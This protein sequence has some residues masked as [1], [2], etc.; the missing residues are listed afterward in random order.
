MNAKA[1]LISAL[2]EG[3]VLNVLNCA[4]EVGLTNVAREIP[5]MVEDEFNVVVSRTPRKAKNRYGSAVSYTDYR[6][7]SIPFNKDG[8]K[9]MRKYVD[10]V[11]KE[12]YQKSLR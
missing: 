9:E 1:A 8:M 2:L 4:K 6:L 11:K 5:R 10:K 12:Y 3:R 7:N